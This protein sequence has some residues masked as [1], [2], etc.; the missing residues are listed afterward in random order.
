[1]LFHSQIFLL[2]FLP[3]VLAVYY[4]LAARG[5]PGGWALIVASLVFYG[6]WDARLL[7]LLGGSITVNWVFARWYTAGRGG[8][9]D[10]R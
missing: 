7:P 5:R 2:L 9:R 8:A 6:F 10:R 4:G 3:L 1:M